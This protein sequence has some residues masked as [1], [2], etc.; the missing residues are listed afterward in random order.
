MSTTVPSAANY[1]KTGKSYIQ[2]ST[3]R[4]KN[5][6]MGKLKVTERGKILGAEWRKAK[7]SLGMP[8]SAPRKTKK[9][10]ATKKKRV[11]A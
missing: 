4:Q 2:Y 8:V 10:S 9:A 5:P 7:K 6:D 3:A 1:L 11:K